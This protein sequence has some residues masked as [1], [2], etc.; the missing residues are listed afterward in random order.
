MVSMARLATLGPSV[1]KTT[2]QPL[3]YGLQAFLMALTIG[4]VLDIPGR[5]GIALYL[6]QFLIATVGVAL[7]LVFMMVPIRG[8]GMTEGVAPPPQ[9]TVAVYDLVL[10]A[11]GFGACFY[12]AIRYQSLIT[13][14]VYRPWDGV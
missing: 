7:A 10:S 6:E 5:L 11:I 4:W 12:V 13:E 3:I 2:L 8:A 1:S 9:L 14:L